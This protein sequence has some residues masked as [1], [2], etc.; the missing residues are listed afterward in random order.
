MSDITATTSYEGASSTDT[1]IDAKDH[2]QTSSQQQQQQWHW[3]RPELSACPRET[4]RQL[5][6]TGKAWTL[7]QVRQ[8]RYKDDAWIA[9]DGKVRGLWACRWGVTLVS[10]VVMHDDSSQND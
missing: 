8:H 9:V 6:A 3:T 1:A 10:E 2:P 7:D 4:R 5:R